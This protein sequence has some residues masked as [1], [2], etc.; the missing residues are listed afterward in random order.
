MS[1][2]SLDQDVTCNLKTHKPTDVC[3][4]IKCIHR[5]KEESVVICKTQIGIYIYFYIYSN[6]IISSSGAR[7]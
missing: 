6:F 7:L 5:K 3:S 1:T 4:P 2:V